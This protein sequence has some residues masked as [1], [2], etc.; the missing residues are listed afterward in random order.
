M[1]LIVGGQPCTA[2]FAYTRCTAYT[3]WATYPTEPQPH[4][5]LHPTLHSH[6]PG[7]EDGCARTFDLANGA[8]VSAFRA[9]GA[10]GGET[11]NGCEFHPYLPFL[12]TASGQRRFA[13]AASDSDSDAS[14]SDGGGAEE[15]GSGGGGHR[16]ERTEN[17]L[18]VWQF[19]CTWE[20]VAAGGEAAPA[21][22]A[23]P[24]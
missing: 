4:R 15:G 23:E 14:S 6:A 2:T 12:A 1:R 8:P 5:T 22:A 7:G 9:S 21:Q 10:P 24:A 17:S 18:C 20:Q 16:L 3:R 19:G 11:I 13:G